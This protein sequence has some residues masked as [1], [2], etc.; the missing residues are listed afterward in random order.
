[1]KSGNVVEYRIALVGKIGAERV[2]WL[3]YDNDCRTF[4]IE[5][6]KRVKRI[7]SRRARH[8]KKLRGIS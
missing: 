5:Y 2:S 6:L 7:F 4:D 3:E 1:M 8:Y